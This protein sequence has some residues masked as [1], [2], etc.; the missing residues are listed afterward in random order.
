MPTIITLSLYNMHNEW[1]MIALY[2][3]ATFRL[4]KY[5]DSVMIKTVKAN[6]AH[7][8]GGRDNGYNQK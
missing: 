5:N 7:E 2:I 6:Q 3:C 8:I 1:Y 4:E